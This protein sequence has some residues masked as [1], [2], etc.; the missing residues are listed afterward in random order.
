MKQ[1]FILAGLT[2]LFAI[3]LLAGC[4]ANPQSGNTL[5]Q[6]SNTAITAPAGGKLVVNFEGRVSAVE[7][8]KVTLEDGR[9]V[10][11]GDAYIY[12]PD[13]SAAAIAVGDF[14]QGHADDPGAAELNATAILITVL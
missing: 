9:V 12:A 5:N 7:D 3:S 8:G 6:T 11:T 2:S 10:R 13:G 1:K 4:A 14:I